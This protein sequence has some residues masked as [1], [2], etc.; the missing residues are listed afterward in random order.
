MDFYGPHQKN[1]PDYYN[2]I[3]KIWTSTNSN[4]FFH[5]DE[6]REFNSHLKTG[7]LVIDV[8]C[9][10]GVHAPL[11]LGLG[12]KLEYEGL[13]ISDKMIE[14][15]KSRYPQLNF[16]VADILDRESLP[17][18]KY[19]AFW[20]GAVLMHVPQEQWSV[21]FDNLQSLVKHG[22]LGYFSLPTFRPSEPT[23]IDQRHFTLMDDKET[24]NF[25]KEKNWQVIAKGLLKTKSKADWRWYLV[26]TP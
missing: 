8:G 13:D 18:K 20:A 3:A 25:L 23:E 11:F 4:S 12:Q 1:K 5:E 26:K 9:A 17:N 21:M 24:V 2:L 15:A 7:N 6:F 19:D 14:I 10:S 16:F 22:S